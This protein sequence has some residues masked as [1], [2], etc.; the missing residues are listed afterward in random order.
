M[1]IER[2]R[3]LN[4]LQDFALRGHGVIIGG[5][6]VGKTYLLREL[7]RNLET[8]EIPEL[9]LPID[10]LGDGTD[11]T[12]RQEL[13]IEENLIEFLESISF[14]QRKGIILFDA[15]DAARNERTRKNFL[16][17]IQCAI[18]ELDK[19]NIIV[20]VRTYDATKSQELLDMFG[21]P[22]EEDIFEYQSKDICCR[23]FTIPPF[24]EDEILQVLDQIKCPQKIYFGGS[25]DFKKI[26]ATPFN[27]WLLEKIIKTSR[28]LPDFSQIHSEVQLFQMFWQRRIKDASKELILNRI[29]QQ[30]VEEQSLSVKQDDIYENLELDKPQRKAALDHLLSDEIL[31]KVSSTGQRIAFSHNILF[32]YAISVLLIEDEPQKFEEFITADLSRPLFLRPSLTYFFTRLWYY[33]LESFWNAFWHILPSNQS[34][35]LRLVARLIPTSVIANETREDRQLEPLIEKLQNGEPIA[36]EAIIRLF[37]ALQTLQIKHEKPWIDFFDKTSEY[38]HSG[39][40]WDMANLTTDILEKTTEQDIKVVCGRIGRRLL[41]WVWQE[42]K[43]NEDDWYNRFGGRWAVP[44]VAKTYDTDAEKSRMLLKKVLKLTEEENFPIG[45]LS[46]LTDNVDKIWVHDPEFV[47]S[48]YQTVFGYYETSNE[49]VRMGSYVLPMTSFRAQDYSMCQYRLVKHFPNFLRA[50]PLIATAAGIQSL[51][52]F[53]LMENVIPFLREK[54]SLK[55]IAENFTF[56]NQNAY[57]VEDGSYI[58]SARKSSDEPLEMAE[59]I[60]LFMKELAASEESE[61]CLES[62][63]DVFRDNVVVAFFWKKLLLIGSQSPKFFAARLFELC[64]AKPIQLHSE[65]FYELGLFLKSASSDFNPKQLLQIEESILGYPIDITDDEDHCNLLE[66]QR[67]KLLAQI[68]LELLKTKR[69]KEIHQDMERKN[70]VPENRPLV[71]FHT[72]WESVTEEKLLKE[73][74]IDTH[75]RE[76]QVILKLIKTS[77]TIQF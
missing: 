40:A 14:S 63:L 21:N 47:A 57:F 76:N 30:M 34:V 42:R 15:F 65:C 3:L 17:L 44:L 58:W 45:F 77:C 10:Q 9:F 51:N 5:P 35:H 26:L 8:A 54:V 36:N 67:N 64:I 50:E 72:G 13:L 53:I 23:H 25:Q 29:A 68:P 46:W 27:L 59:S 6:G 28:E 73:K 56:R 24:S 22:D 49:E 74:G 31:T 19:W 11:E 52:V 43:I 60:F 41:K 4:N 7:R 75:K 38:L 18:Q 62:L 61:P 70:N 2:D 20:T 55:D 37:Q 1:K 69:A 12:L 32:D 48:I 16:N 71:S 33:N 39:F 66:R